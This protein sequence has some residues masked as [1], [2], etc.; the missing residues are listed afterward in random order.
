MTD[1]AHDDL[2]NNYSR[3]KSV[4][5]GSSSTEKKKKVEVVFVKKFT[6]V[7]TPILVLL[8][9]SIPVV[10]GAAVYFF[11]SQTVTH[12]IVVRGGDGLLLKPGFADYMA[13]TPI[14]QL[15]TLDENTQGGGNVVIA[16]SAVLVLEAHN[17]NSDL[18]L[19]VD[20][21]MSDTSYTVTVTA[22]YIVH[23]VDGMGGD[24]TDVYSIGAVP[25][26][27]DYTIAVADIPKMEWS[28]AVP[29]GGSPAVEADASGI[30]LAFEFTDG[31]GWGTKTFDIVV[32]LGI[33]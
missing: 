11:E 19:L 28:T 3:S 32:S 16:D 5:I 15:E 12:Q 6:K 13:K 4:G 23:W 14:S 10:I 27:T 22:Y 24:V 17:L 18:D 31:S 2:K 30:L 1:E 21:T 29:W 25:I 7:S 9:L 33:A 20:V 8:L 26:G